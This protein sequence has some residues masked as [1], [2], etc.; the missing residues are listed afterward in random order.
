MNQSNRLLHRVMEKG[1]SECARGKGNHA[2]RVGEASSPMRG[3]DQ[4]RNGA[5][6]HELRSW[7][8]KRMDRAEAG[9]EAKEISHYDYTL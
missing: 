9:H 5:M 3:G 7:Q 1:A 6:P 8:S 2:S 4:L